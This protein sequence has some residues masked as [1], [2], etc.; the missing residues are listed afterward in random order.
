MATKAARTSI[1]LPDKG[2]EAAEG[3]EAAAAA[4]AVAAEAA[5]AKTAEAEAA[6]EQLEYQ[7]DMAVGPV[8]DESK[9]ALAQLKQLCSRLSRIERPEATLLYAEMMN[10]RA[11]LV[12]AHE[13]LADVEP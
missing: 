6:L 2:R 11:K 8:I 9:A 4:A 1:A 5:Q 10:T 3:A 13:W 7:D 12:H